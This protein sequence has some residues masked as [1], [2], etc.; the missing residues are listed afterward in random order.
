MNPTIRRIAPAI[1]PGFVRYKLVPVYE[2]GGVLLN[3]WM[4]R[5]S[6]AN[7]FGTVPARPNVLYIEGTNICNARCVFCAYPQMERPKVTMTMDVFHS[8]CCYPS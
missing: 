2:W 7:L 4:M 8:P 3:Y 1:L 6:I 5:S